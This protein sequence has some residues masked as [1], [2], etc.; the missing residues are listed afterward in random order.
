MNLFL[1]DELAQ[2]WQGQDI[3]QRLLELDGEIF[4]QVKG[5]RTLRFVLHGKGYFLK[6]HLGVGWGE[7]FKNLVRLR[8]PVVSASNE[9]R[10]LQRLSQLGIAAPAV[11]GYGSRGWNPAT[12]QSFIITRELENTVDLEAYCAL[13]PL[14][15][16]GFAA[17]RALI[18]AVGRISRQLHGAGICHRDYY[19][20]HF[21]L[22]RDSGQMS[23]ASPPR[24]YL[25]DLHRALFGKSP[26]S[27][28][29]KKDIAG[30]YFSSMEIGLTRADRLRFARAYRDAPLRDTLVRDRQFWHDV[31]ARGQALYNKLGNPAGATGPDIGQ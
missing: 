11:A 24:L 3:F 17:K 28:W 15:P 20:C 31:I 18:E 16:P 26:T 13:W 1:V 19:L 22:L 25:I 21:H 10:A 6:L 27:R 29:V 2:A 5:R 12:R 30:L 7:I 4:R 23:A 8:L 14:T 9:W